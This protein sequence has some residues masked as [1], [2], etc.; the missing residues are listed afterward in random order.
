M[1]TLS[2]SAPQ[3]LS[4]SNIL[5]VSPSFG[6]PSASV[7]LT[8]NGVISIVLQSGSFTSGQ[9]IK[10]ILPGTVTNSN[11]PQNAK[12]DVAAGVTDSLGVVLAESAS[13][14]I[15][16]IV[17]GSLHAAIR[18]DWRGS[19][20]SSVSLS[21]F[22]VPFCDIASGSSIVIT[23]SGSAPQSLSASTVIFTSPSTGSP[24]AT[25]SLAGGVL[26]VT[27]S[28][29]TFSSGQLIAFSL[30]GTIT[31]AGSVQ[32]P[33]NNVSVSIV[34][35]NNFTRSVN[36]TVFFHAIHDSSAMFSHWLT[37]FSTSSVGVKTAGSFRI[38]AAT[39][40]NVLVFTYPSR[41]FVSSRC[42]FAIK[43]LIAYLTHDF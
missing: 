15:H 32:P 37:G 10:F 28:S 31:N 1:I 8:L 38:Q 5:F 27:T 6:S 41:L 43:I 39:V 16:S 14:N 26:T 2:G 24:A 35:S 25:A 19:G 30:P 13:G 21:A 4:A 29:G 22:F 7:S 20:T 11:I 23:L 34:D 42:C 36:R 18:L 3:S 33:L 9:N 12:V 17:D 40:G